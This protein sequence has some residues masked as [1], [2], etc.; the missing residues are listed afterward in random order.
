MLMHI[1]DIMWWWRKDE[2]RVVGYTHNLT[3]THTRLNTD[4]EDE[5]L[6]LGQD[7]FPLTK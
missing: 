3:H 4:C 6:G 7:H 2:K 5:N 1:V